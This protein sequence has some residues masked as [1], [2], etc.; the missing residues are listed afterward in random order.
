MSYD[1]APMTIT[2]VECGGTANRMSYAPPDEGF[3]PGDVIAYVCEDCNHR[4]DTVW[5]GPGGEEP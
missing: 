3:R 1:D 5:E 4:M 2:C